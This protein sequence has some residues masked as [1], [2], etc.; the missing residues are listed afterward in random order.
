MRI[1]GRQ[2]MP[3]H[4]LRVPRCSVECPTCRLA[5]VLYYITTS[6]R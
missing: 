2:Y 1:M 4:E 5:L 6:A 3:R